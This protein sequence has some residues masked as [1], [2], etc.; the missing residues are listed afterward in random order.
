MI[1]HRVKGYGVVIMTNSDT[2]GRLAREMRDRISHAYAWDMY[3]KPIP[4]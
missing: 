3:D 1:A 4:R 2:G